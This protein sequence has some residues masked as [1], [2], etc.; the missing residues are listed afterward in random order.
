MLEVTDL[1]TEKEEM[2]VTVGD[3]E[4]QE[5]CH[6]VSHLMDTFWKLLAIRPPNPMLAPVC[7]PGKFFTVKIVIIYL[8]IC[9]NI[10][11]GCSKE[12]SHGEGSFEH[13]QHMFW[14]QNEKID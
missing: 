4:P 13:P 2:S 14:F 1:E 3:L 8:P 5:K 11:F 10:Y 7:L 9:L 12:L 6:F